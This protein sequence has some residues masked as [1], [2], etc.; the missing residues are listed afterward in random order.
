MTTLWKDLGLSY[1][2]ALHGVQTGIKFEMETGQSQDTEP[3]HLRVGVN[4]AMTEHAALAF[5]LIKK[6]VITKEEYIEEL[7]LAMNQELSLYEARYGI[8]FR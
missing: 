7:R 5:L 8:T 6:G 2:Q 3:K 4:A 1:G